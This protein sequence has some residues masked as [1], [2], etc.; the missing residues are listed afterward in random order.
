ML[1]DIYELLSCKQDLI[2]LFK[3]STSIRFYINRK[4][5]FNKNMND[6]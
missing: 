3:L 1:M 4:S 6:V 2:T 5:Y